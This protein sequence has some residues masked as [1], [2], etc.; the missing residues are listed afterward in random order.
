[1]QTGAELKA[2]ADAERKQD[3]EVV[4]LNYINA[5]TAS[6]FISPLLSASGTIALNG[7]AVANVLPSLSDLGSN[8]F[9]HE[10]VMLIRD[11]PEN[12]AQIKEKLAELDIK[13]KQV[14]VETTILQASVNEDNAFGIDIQGFVDVDSLDFMSPLGTTAGG[15]TSAISE[16]VSGGVGDGG[17]VGT[18]VAPSGESSFEIGIVAN[19][20]AILIKALDSVTDTTILSNPKLTVLN[21]QRANL[22]VGRRL[23]YISTT[24]TETS[25]T[26]TVEFLDTGTQ[27]TVRPFVSFDEELNADVIRME[28]EPSISSGFVEEISGFVVPTEDTQSVTT[29]VL[30]RSGQT[31]VI[32][33]L[34]EETSTIGRKQ[35]PFLGDVPVLGAA[36]RG[37]DDD[38]NRRETIFMLTPSVVK[39]SQLAKIGDYAEHSGSMARLAAQE[40]LLPFSRTKRA[41]HHVRDA[42]DA[43]DAGDRERALMA[44]NMALN[45]DPGMEEARRLRQNITG[46]IEELQPTL[47][48]LD[49]AID[50][51][52]DENAP[53]RPAK[54]TTGGEDVANAGNDK[55]KADVTVEVDGV[56]IDTRYIQP[57]E[58]EAA[59]AP[60]AMEVSTD[61]PAE[62]QTEAQTPATPQV[63]QVPDADATETS[64]EFEQ[65]QTDA[66]DE[67]ETDPFAEAMET[68]TEADAEGESLSDRLAVFEPESADTQTEPAQPEIVEVPVGTSDADGFF[69]EPEAADDAVATTATTEDAAASEN[70]AEADE[71]IR[72]DATA[73]VDTDAESE[74]FDVVDAL[75]TYLP[76]DIQEVPVDDETD[77]GNE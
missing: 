64:T 68:E 34:F 72:E 39:D 75:S 69:A 70:I 33:G 43:M 61:A 19:E 53:R 31:I 3:A 45:I 35:V 59:A 60:D 55:D 63:P 30:V 76:A 25:E 51:M 15:M 23:G 28:I 18:R 65:P 54:A 41:S 22:L 10:E 29:N 48:I 71:A 5:T 52:V 14:L 67:F 37:Q 46:E 24:T 13:P 21:R 42:M 2:I 44:A 27:L 47:Q 32:G 74:A 9:A 49:N 26:Q 57:G 7:E 1:V 20:I 17:S 36:F 38:I 73:T 16:L 77:G 12:I 50:Q 58:V 11:Y 40:K 6:T 62:P 66:A 8:S 56:Q 4:R